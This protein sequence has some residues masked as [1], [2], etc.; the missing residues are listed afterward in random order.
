MKFKE[1]M[2]FEVTF[3]PT[4][5]TKSVRTV[6]KFIIYRPRQFLVRFLARFSPRFSPSLTIPQPY[7]GTARGGSQRWGSGVNCFDIVFRWSTAGWTFNGFGKLFS[8]LFF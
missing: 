1:Y 8:A 5:S 7:S 6:L 3:S 2:G 4:S